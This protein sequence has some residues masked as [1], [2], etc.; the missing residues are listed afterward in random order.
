MEDRLPER[1]AGP[2]IGPRGHVCL[3]EPATPLGPGPQLRHPTGDPGRHPFK[4]RLQ[5]LHSCLFFL[6]GWTILLYLSLPVIYIFT[7]AQPFTVSTST[8]ML[9]YFA[10]YY[11]ISLIAVAAAGGGSYTFEAYCLY[12]ANFWIQIAATIFVLTGSKMKW[13][14][15]AKQSSQR[16]EPGSV[17]P[18]LIA[19]GILAVTAVYGIAHGLTSAVANNLAF[20]GMYAADHADRDLARPDRRPGP[21]RCSPRCRHPGTGGSVRGT[22]PRDDV[23]PDDDV[24]HDVVPDHV[25]PDDFWPDEVG[26]DEVEAGPTG[27]TEET[28]GSS[29]FRG[30][31]ERPP[32]GTRRVV[33]AVLIV[34]LIV[35]AVAALSVFGPRDHR[36]PGV[37][38][39]PAGHHPTI[40]LAST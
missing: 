24:E 7:G 5:Y 4:I 10:P 37:G 32:G 35:S 39:G 34:V 33:V 36:H 31:T 16:R 1:G 9:L 8:E 25:G 23:G 18:A 14:V 15:T 28:R 17:V 27:G 2:G 29:G 22:A 38:L 30:S 19:I 21:H 13:V 40:E 20:A 6:T 12:I 3:R 26:P 11:I